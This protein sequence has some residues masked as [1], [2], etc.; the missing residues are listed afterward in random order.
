MPKLFPVVLVVLGCLSAPARAQ[1]TA[2]PF[3]N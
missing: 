1:E 2:A 3:D